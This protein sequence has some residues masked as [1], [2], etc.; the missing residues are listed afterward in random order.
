MADCWARPAQCEGCE[1]DVIGGLM[2]RLE[3]EYLLVST[4]PCFLSLQPLEMRQKDDSGSCGRFGRQKTQYAHF[5]LASSF[6]NTTL[7]KRTADIAQGKEGT[8]GMA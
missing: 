6:L 7:S 1:E 2:H 8:R 5:S 4:I 3:C